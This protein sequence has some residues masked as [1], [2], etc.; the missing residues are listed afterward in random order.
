M[1]KSDTF[2]IYISSMPKTKKMIQ[3]IKTYYEWSY[4]PTYYPKLLV[5]N[6]SDRISA[7][8]RPVLHPL[9]D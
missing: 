2:S 6:Q 3:N 1:I 5:M 9:T 4:Q 7:H 8:K